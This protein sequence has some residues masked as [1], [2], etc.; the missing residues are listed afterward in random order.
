MWKYIE[1]V[2]S[3]GVDHRW[4][5]FWVEE[6]SVVGLKKTRGTKQVCAGQTDSQEYILYSAMN[7]KL[8]GF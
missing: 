2:V 5:K 6:T 3:E 7:I 8:H 1:D 4:H